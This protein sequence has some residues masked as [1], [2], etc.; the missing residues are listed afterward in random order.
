MGKWSLVG[1]NVRDK[2][3]GKSDGV[4]IEWHHH[5]NSSKNNKNNGISKPGCEKN[6][7]TCMVGF[8]KYIN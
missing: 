3:N 1:F 4:Y 2:V 7:Q 5:H 6:I 8:K